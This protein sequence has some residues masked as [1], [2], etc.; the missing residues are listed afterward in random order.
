[1]LYYTTCLSQHAT[2][3]VGF[4]NQTHT[5]TQSFN[6]LFE[7]QTKNQNQCQEGIKI[8]VLAGYAGFD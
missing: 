6:G 4:E 3:I 2:I 1:M 5:H 8:R 7:N